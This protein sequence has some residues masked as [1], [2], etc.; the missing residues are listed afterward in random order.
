[1]TSASLQFLNLLAVPYALVG[2]AEDG[3]ENLVG[4]G[5]VDVGAELIPPGT[6][7]TVPVPLFPT[8]P[9]VAGTFALVSTIQPLPSAYAT[10]VG[11]WKRLADGCP[12]GAAQALLDAMNVTS[13]RDVVGANGCRPM[14]AT[15]LD[16][17]LQPLLAA[18]PA[19][20][21]LPAIAADLT[22]IAA[23]VTLQSTL[24]VTAI[25]A[26]GY[27]AEHALSTAQFKVGTTSSPPYD[28]VGRGEPVIDDKDVALSTDG[29][30]VTIG[31]HGFTL[32]WRPL[33]LQALTD[34]ALPKEVPTLPT[35]ATVPSLVSAIVASASHGGKMGCA[36]VDDLVCA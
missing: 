13:H 20:G 4:Y 34:V 30:L 3:N 11:T 7:S 5:C 33:W 2:E 16:A 8:V 26:T 27:S 35:P 6:V 14:S 28:L 21:A 24:T 36:G 31:A 32:G 9:S 19:T 10:V 22:A 1:M 29:S 12:Y 23:T 25:S 17:Q 18:A 15:S